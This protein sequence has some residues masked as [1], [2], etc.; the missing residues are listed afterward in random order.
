MLIREDTGIGIAGEQLR[1]VF[2]EF[3]QVGASPS[4]MREG[5]VRSALIGDTS[6][7]VHCARLP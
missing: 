2:D 4:A 1:A 6:I 3:C 7:D 5:S